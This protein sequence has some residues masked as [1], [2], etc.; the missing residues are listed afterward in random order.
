M[1]EETK[2]FFCDIRKCDPVEGLQQFKSR[3]VVVDDVN[4]Q[5]Q[6]FHFVLGPKKLSGILHFDQTE[7]RPSVGDCMIIHYYVRT[8]DDKKN[9]GHQKKVIEVIKAEAT[10]VVNSDLVK[11]ISGFLE[12]KYKGGLDWGRP[13]FAFIGDYYVHK[14]LLEKYKIHSDCYVEAKAVL[15]GDDKWRVYEILNIE[16]DEEE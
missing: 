16:K 14:S 9:P 13:D 11:K 3:T 8:I 6:L 10:E 4:T 5:K 1:K 12:V 2:V 7:L 15:T